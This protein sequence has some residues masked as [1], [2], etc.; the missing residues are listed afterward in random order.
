MTEEKM[1]GWHHGL[2]GHEFEEAPEMVKD[3]KAWHAALHGVAKSWKRLYNRTKTTTPYLASLETHDKQS[4][5][6]AGGLGPV[7]EK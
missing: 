2:N 5:C 4:A 3:K 7:L 1:V 6:N